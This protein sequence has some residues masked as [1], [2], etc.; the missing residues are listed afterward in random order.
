ASNIIIST[1]ARSR[2]LPSMKIDDK[3]ITGYRKAMTLETLPKKMG[4]V[5]SGAIGAEFAYFYASLGTEV[6]VVEYMDRIVPVEDA[7][8]SK[9]LERI[10]KKAGMKIM[11][12][13]EVTAVDTK[14]DGCKVT[15]KTAKGEQTLECDIVL[16]AAGVVA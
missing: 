13:S 16:S 6:T 10:Y 8:V 4:V 2:E 11:T 3:K 9:A 12:S 7:E 1:G 5:G 14:G 15:V